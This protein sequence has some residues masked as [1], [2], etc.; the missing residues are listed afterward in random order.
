MYTVSRSGEP[1]K[2]TMKDVTNSHSSKGRDMMVKIKKSTGQKKIIVEAD[3]DMT[4]SGGCG[5]W[6]CHG[7]RERGKERKMKKIEKETLFYKPRK[8]LRII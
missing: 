3:G 7:E 5:Q 2:I 6:Y 4:A 8:I 1:F